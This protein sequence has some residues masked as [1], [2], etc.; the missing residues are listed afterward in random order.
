MPRYSYQCTECGHIEERI[1][2][3]KDCD[4]SWYC[5]CGSVQTRQ[6]EAPF[7]EGSLIYPFK[8]W[9]LTDETITVKDKAHHKKLLAKYNCDSP[10]IHVG[11]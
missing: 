6:V 8:L 5:V 4:L 2:T 3:I 11:G 10:A 1:H 9:N 7:I